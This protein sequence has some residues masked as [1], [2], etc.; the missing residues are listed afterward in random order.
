MSAVDYFVVD[1]ETANQARNSICQIGI[2]LF[3]DGKMVDGWE[4]LVNPLDEFAARCRAA[5][6]RAADGGAG[7]L[8]ERNLPQGAVDARGR[9][10]CQPHRF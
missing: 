6:H 10:G 3:A 4:S 5:R 7:S 1:V 2:A 8:L 9:G